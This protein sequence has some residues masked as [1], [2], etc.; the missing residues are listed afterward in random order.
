MKTT[1]VL[2]VVL[3]FVMLVIISGCSSETAVKTN[4]EDEIK[5]ST[6]SNSTIT[7]TLTEATT[8]LSTKD[9]ITLENAPKLEDNMGKAPT[10]MATINGV[11]YL[12]D[13]WRGS[14]Y[15]ASSEKYF[16]FNVL[17][18]NPTEEN[19]HHLAGVYFTAEIDG[20]EYGGNS[21]SEQT[22]L[23][24]VMKEKYPNFVFSVEKNDETFGYTL[25]LSGAEEIGIVINTPLTHS[26]QFSQGNLTLN[27]SDF[28][29]VCLVSNYANMVLE[30]SGE[31]T[32]SGL[33]F[34]CNSPGDGVYDYNN[35]KNCKIVNYLTLGSYEYAL[36]P[37]YDFRFYGGENN[38]VYTQFTNINKNTSAY[39]GESR[40]P[41]ITIGGAVATKFEV[42]AY[43][44]GFNIIEDA[45]NPNI[46]SDI[47]CIISAPEYK[48]DLTDT[49]LDTEEK[50]A[51]LQNAYHD[52]IA[53]NIADEVLEY[54]FNTNDYDNTPVRLS[55]PWANI[56]TEIQTDGINNLLSA[57]FLFNAPSDGSVYNSGE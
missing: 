54:R 53:N 1:K 16:S 25:S 51:T 46:N 30:T 39:R 35:L 52:Q 5:E 49:E 44:S 9:G 21:F 29:N 26:N 37:V 50:V 6:K 18:V 7:E 42:V 13:P 43:N 3:A 24:Q 14:Y 27:I 10:Y 34:S 33:I 2:S 36:D 45:E 23:N 20:K 56:E 28:N 12:A 38:T 17:T 32:N 31:I 57:N 8:V 22:T 19:G 4:S 11:N 15:E 41:D 47:H 40:T 55:I 48:L